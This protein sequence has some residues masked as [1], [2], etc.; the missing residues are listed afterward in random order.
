MPRG[1]RSD[2]AKR[3]EQPDGQKRIV[4][5]RPSC[6]LLDESERGRGVEELRLHVGDERGDPAG[7]SGTRELRLDDRDGAPPGLEEER[8]AAAR[9]RHAGRAAQPDLVR[10]GAAVLRSAAQ[11][12]PVAARALEDDDDRRARARTARRAGGRDRERAFVRTRKNATSSARSGRPKAAAERKARRRS[13][14]RLMSEGRHAGKHLGRSVTERHGPS[15]GLRGAP[16]DVR[17]LSAFA[18]R[19]KVLP[20]KSR[21][22]MSRGAAGSPCVRAA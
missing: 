1:R 14:A 12:Q 18:E 13:A 5:R 8:V 6:L 10:R 9:E 22:S 20:G 11:E 16:P 7:D 19:A 4:Q 15:A 2:G 3:P 17:K 21:S